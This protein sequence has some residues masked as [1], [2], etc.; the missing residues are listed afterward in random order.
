[1]CQYSSVDGAANHWHLVHLGSRAIGGAGLILIEATGV[2]A[3]GRISAGDLGIWSDAQVE[4][5]LPITQFMREHNCVAGIQL[6]H[7]GRKASVKAPWKGGT[8]VPP[9]APGGW[10]T[11]AP[12]A[13]P[14]HDNSHPPKA[15]TDD[16]IASVI[17][18]F[19][20]AAKRSL[21]A[22]FQVAEIH[23]AHGYLLH[24][25]L[26]PLT[27]KRTEKFGGSLENRMR[28][29]LAV[30]KAVRDVWP[31]D[32]PVFVRIS[33]TDWVE[34]GWDLQQSITFV[35][36]LKSIGIDLIDCST[37]GLVPN[38]KIPVGPAFQTPFAEAIRKE[39]GMA[40]GSVGL[41]TEPKQADDIISQNRADAVLIARASLRDAYW[42]LHAAGELNAEIPWPKQYERAK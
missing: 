27:N 11:L 33:A 12:S 40:L 41:I 10:Q 17:D 5:L 2:S 38:A 9:S 34:G 36:E 23:M 1:M 6:A 39:T 8:P 21:K 31:H 15:M 24:Q 4:S 16:D 25:F 3:V 35:H 32:L 18:E 37:G 14:F 42:P 28:F 20:S 30:A 22:G 29:P 19:T 7:A 26:S 13:I